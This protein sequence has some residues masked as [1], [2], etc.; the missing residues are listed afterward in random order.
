M[1]TRS[2]A[3]ITLHSDPLEPVGSGMAGGMTVYLFGLSRQ[4]VALGDRVDLITRRIDPSQPDV[5]EVEPGLRVRYIDAGDPVFVGK[6][7]LPALAPLAVDALLAGER[8]DLVYS[9]YGLSGLVGLPVARAWGVPHVQTFHTVAALTD[10]LSPADAPRQSEVRLRNEA[11]L[12]AESDLILALSAGEAAMIRGGRV[13]TVWPGIDRVMF[14][15]G[16]E[17]RGYVLVAARLHKIKGLELA[18]D[19]LGQVPEEIRPELIVAGDGDEGYRAQLHERHVNA[20]VRM[21]ILGRLEREEMATLMREAAI[22]LVPS[23]SETFGLVAAEAAA[24]GVPV[25]ANPVGGLSDSVS[26]IRL[27]GRDPEVWGAAITSLLTDDAL[28]G[29]L[30]AEAREFS[31]RFD[32]AAAGRRVHE[33]FDELITAAEARR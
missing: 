8:Y 26:G 3:L 13:E 12:V 31:A 23:Y 28:R 10:A 17:N 21:R 27:E 22:V 29:R 9:N 32:E 11:S 1:T 15:P 24:S 18:I 2:L 6:A 4:L 16:E 5:V 33:L 19:A 30:G 7:D 14:H 25:I 20:G